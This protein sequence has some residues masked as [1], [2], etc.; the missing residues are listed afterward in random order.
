MRRNAC[1][2]VCP[3]DGSDRCDPDLPPAP[4]LSPVR[5]LSAAEVSTLA[6]KLLAYHQRFAPLFQRREQREWAALYLRSLLT[7]EVPRKNVEAMP[8]RLLGAKPHAGRQVRAAQQFVGE[9]G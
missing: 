5:E 3:H 6:E 2:E 8:L 7:A 4:G 9:G 1:P